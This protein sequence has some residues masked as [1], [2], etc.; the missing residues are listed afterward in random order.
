MNYFPKAIVTVII[1]FTVSSLTAQQIE[2]L[3]SGPKTS[4]RGLSVVSDDIIW[5]SG[6]GGKVGKS[7]NAV[8][9]G[10]G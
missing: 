7:I 3:T 10:N 6:S 1:L 5:V 8:K 9:P 2:I 4:I